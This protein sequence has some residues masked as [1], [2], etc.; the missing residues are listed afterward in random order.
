MDYYRN[1][2]HL[3]QDGSRL[4]ISGTS[5]EVVH[6]LYAE[7]VDLE[8]FKQHERID[9]DTDDALCLMY[10]KAARIELERYTMLSFGAKTMGFMALD[11]PSGYKLMFG[12]VESI[13]TPGFTN[14]GDL[15]RQ[16][17]RNVEIEYTTKDTY[18][19]DDMVK[20]AICRYAATLY[21][22]REGLVI[23]RY[24]DQSSIDE[25]KKMLDPIRNIILF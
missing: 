25:A 6:D 21:A 20:T 2:D 14:F 13:I 17:G 10:I 11:V 4:T 12:P 23:S 7:P 9:F 8:T 24:H 15:L 19:D 3:C 5:Y 16:G 18:F 1:F 22:F